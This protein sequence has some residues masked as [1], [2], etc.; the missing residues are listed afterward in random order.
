M[1]A[2]PLLALLEI[3]PPLTAELPSKMLGLLLVP[4]LAMLAVPL[5]TLL[6]I[7]PPSLVTIL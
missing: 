6:E 1:L 4:I 2:V 5:L 7:A 3:A